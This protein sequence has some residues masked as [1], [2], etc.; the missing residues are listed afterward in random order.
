LWQPSQFSN[1]WRNHHLECG[2]FVVAKQGG[3][4]VGTMLLMLEDADFWDDHPR[5]EAVFVHKVA[6]SRAYAGLGVTAALLE[7]AA[8]E[9]LRLERKFVRL[10]C[11]LRQKLV[12]LYE[13]M[14]LCVLTNAP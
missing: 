4:V 8:S 7:F 2:E 14:V 1:E 3:T 5:G 13:K 11:A 6:V 10:D 9:A 12:N